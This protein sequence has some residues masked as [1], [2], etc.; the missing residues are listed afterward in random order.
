MF[1]KKNA[2]KEVNYQNIFDTCEYDENISKKLKIANTTPCKDFYN[3]NRTSKS[4][5]GKFEEDQHKPHKLQRL[6]ELEK[7]N[8]YKTLEV[9]ELADSETIKRRYRNLCRI[10]HP[11]KG[12]NTE[13]FQKIQDAYKVLSNDLF[14][15]LYDENST[16]AISLIDYLSA[17]EI[18][19]SEDTKY[20][21]DDIN[22]LIQMNN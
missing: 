7:N 5:S 14:R 15:K 16:R 9:D 10:H 13:H 11:D 2:K 3:F 19:I 1:G 22:L 8:L 4:G 17:N 12:G 21:I 20:D 6:S 18:H